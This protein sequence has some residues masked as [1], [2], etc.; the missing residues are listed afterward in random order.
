MTAN[1]AVPIRMRSPTGFRYP[2]SR[3]ASTAPSTHTRPADNSS[4]APRN[5]PR[6]MDRRR[7]VA[8]V[9]LTPRT[10][11]IADRSSCARR[12][13]RSRSGDV[14]R[15]SGTCGATRRARCASTRIYEHH[16]LA[17]VDAAHDFDQRLTRFAHF[18][19]TRLYAVGPHHVH[20]WLSLFVEDC[21]RRQ[22]HDAGSRADD[23]IG[24]R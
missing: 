17:L 16:P 3:R 20:H 23:E 5:R 15:V 18:D 9:G 10:R 12:R 1:T 22:E 19:R 14:V 7:I 4:T 2:N 24:A 6:S 11:A 8:Y 21:A 13:Y